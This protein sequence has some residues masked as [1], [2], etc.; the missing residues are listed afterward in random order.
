MKKLLISGGKLLLLVWLVSALELLVAV[1]L[2]PALSIPAQIAVWFLV[3]AG[4]YVLFERKKGWTYG[5]RQP[6]GFILWIRGWWSGAGMI[7][8]VFLAIWITGG[9]RVTGMR[10]EAAGQAEFWWMIGVLLLAALGEEWM[11]RG[12]VQGLLMFEYSAWTARTVSSALFALLHGLNPA[13]W[14]SPVPMINL[15][16][17]G[18]LLALLRD[19]TGGIWAPAGF[20]FAW[21][22]LQG[23][24]YGFPVSGQLLADSLILI[25]TA[26]PHWLSGGMFGAE[27][28]LVCTALLVAGILAGVRKAKG[29]VRSE[30]RPVQDRE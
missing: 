9:I 28:S 8:A 24:V 25:E 27:G 1:R 19:L 6:D 29:R 12:Y 17:A 10:P 20:H 11:M 2:P 30:A 23:Q 7:T 16:A 22:L 18:V 13:V 5:I 4:L 14:D 26:G 3:P 15:F 21:N